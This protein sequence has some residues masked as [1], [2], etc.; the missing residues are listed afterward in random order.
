LN[1]LVKVDLWGWLDDPFFR[2]PE[3]ADLAQVRLF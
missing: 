1:L 3:K 2:P